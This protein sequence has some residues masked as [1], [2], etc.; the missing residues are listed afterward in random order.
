M[1]NPKNSPDERIRIPCGNCKK[2]FYASSLSQHRIRCLKQLDKQH[3]CETCGKSFPSPRELRF[4]SR[5]H[6][7]GNEIN[8]CETCGKSF[9][10]PGRLRFHSRL[11]VPG[12]VMKCTI[13]G[14]DGFKTQELMLKL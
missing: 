10:S 3:L 2:T 4:H 5:L 8:F 1:I 13:C 7:P 9:P 12:N 11:H 14:L 6:V